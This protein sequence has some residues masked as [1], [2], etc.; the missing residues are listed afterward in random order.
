MNL[1][2]NFIKENKNYL[3]VKPIKSITFIS[4]SRLTPFQIQTICSFEKFEFQI[5]DYETVRLIFKSCIHLDIYRLIL[6][7]YFS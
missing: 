1:G 6:I 4:E 7:I 2:M 3:K 5:S